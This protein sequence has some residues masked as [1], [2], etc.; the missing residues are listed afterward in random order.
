MY[1]TQLGLGPG[2]LQA[3]RLP[4]PGIVFGQRAVGD[5]SEPECMGRIR[6]ASDV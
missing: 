6:A 5:G 2:V 3:W 4:R 1:I